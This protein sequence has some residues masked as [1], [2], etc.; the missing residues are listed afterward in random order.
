MS[1]E[2]NNEENKNDK[3]EVESRNTEDQYKGKQEYPVIAKD[4][5]PDN[6][7]YQSY[8]YDMNH[9]TVYGY[10][11]KMP[12]YRNYSQEAYEDPYFRYNQPKYQGYDD[13]YT[14]RMNMRM[15]KDSKRKPKMRVCSNCVTTSTTSWRRSTDGKKLL[16]N[17]CGLYQKLH[18]RPRPY[19]TT[20]DGKT[21]ALKS[22]FYKIK[23][24]NCGTTETS[25]WRRGINGHPLCNACGLYFR[26]NSFREKEKEVT[27][28]KNTSVPYN[29]EYKD[30][31]AKEKKMSREKYFTNFDSYEDNNYKYK[32]KKRDEFYAPYTD[33]Y[34]E[35][36]Y[37]KKEMYRKDGYSAY[38]DMYKEYTYQM[39]DTP[40]DGTF[41]KYMSDLKNN[42]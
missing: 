38:N 42:N 17:A 25:F 40:K 29:E 19:S 8:G 32:E 41:Y 36:P 23:C 20:P 9:N 2:K 3:I 16:C 18:G 39:R 12:V 5:F 14:L 26:E 15:H 24:G 31:S 33:M 1:Q 28:E 21:K 4:E 10:S 35:D 34:V 27:R 37:N 6:R 7:N 22:G 11:P 13:Y 30:S